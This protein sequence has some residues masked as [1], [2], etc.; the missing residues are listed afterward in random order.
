[1]YSNTTIERLEQINVERD[2][3]YGDTG[4]QKWIVELNVSSSYVDRTLIHNAREAMRDWDSS[5]LNI[6]RII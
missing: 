3:T 4:Y 1:M 5:K 6:N 2:Q